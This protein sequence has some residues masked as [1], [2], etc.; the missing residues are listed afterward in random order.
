MTSITSNILTHAKSLPEGVTVSA[1]EFLHIGSR[2]AIDQALSRLARN[3]KLFRIGTG[4]YAYPIQTRFG[5][6]PPNFN[7]VIEHIVKKTGEVIAA[8]GA[9]SANRLGL[10][11]QNPMKLVFL[12]SGKTRVLQFK[13]AEVILQNAPDWQLLEPNSVVGHAIRAIDFMGEYQAE[14]VVEK[15]NELLKPDERKSLLA[16]RP[17]VPKWIAEEVSRLAK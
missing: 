17:F 8:P 13:K 4:M 14:W 15:I 6:L 1:R 9:V 7:L 11:T 2:A 16:L 5:I 10:T 3:G 12:T